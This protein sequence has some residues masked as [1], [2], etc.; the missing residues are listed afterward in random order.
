MRMCTHLY[1]DRRQPWM[2]YSYQ[3]LANPNGPCRCYLCHYHCHR[4]RYRHCPYNGPPPPSG[5]RAFLIFYY[6]GPFNII[7]IHVIIWLFSQR[8]HGSYVSISLAVSIEKMLRTP[9][10]HKWK[11]RAHVMHGYIVG[12]HSIKEKKKKSTIYDDYIT[13]QY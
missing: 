6:F 10:L 13:R 12:L 9:L 11:I 2:C 3:R 8:R 1:L 7:K 5:L 4:H